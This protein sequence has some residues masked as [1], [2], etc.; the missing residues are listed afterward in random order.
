MQLKAATATFVLFMLA[1]SLAASAATPKEAVGFMGT[2]TGAVKSAQKDG[3]SFVLVISS[4][5]PNEQSAVKN[6]A[7][8]V[9]KEITLG[10]RMP[11]KDGKPTQ[12]VDDVAWIK[13]LKPGQVVKVKIFAVRADP[14]VL[15][16]TEPG[17]DVT[18]QK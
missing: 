8:M 18:P 1:T 13:T 16:I 15:R 17:Q 4:A 9:G 3:S 14:S 6:G 12:H 2:A 5:E 11:R 10:V 7:A